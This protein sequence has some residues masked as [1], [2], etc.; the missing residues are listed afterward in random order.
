LQVYEK[1]V[2]TRVR[3][4]T[5]AAKA[6]KAGDKEAAKRHKTVADSLKITI[7]G[8]FG[9]LGNKWSTLYAPQ[10]LLQVTISGQLVLLMLIEMLEQA[11]ISVISGNTDGII[12]SYRQHRHD[13]VRAIIAMWEQRT[14]FRTEET[15]YSAIYSRDVNS[16]IAVKI[17]Q[18]DT[19]ARFLDERLGCKTKGA[20]CERGSALNSILSKNPETLVCIDAV[21]ELIKNNVPVEQT[22]RNCKDIKRFLAVRNVKGGGEKNGIYL[23]KVVRWYY[24]K[25]EAGYIAYVASGNKVAKT[26]GAK[27]LMDLPKELPGDID[28]SWYINTANEMLYDCGF[29]KTNESGSL[30]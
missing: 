9:K 16:Y 24:P 25:N 17:E 6:K 5:E 12:L 3:A 7:N 4:K 10:L 8:S 19:E 22:I 29:Y 20:Y 21:L 11:G 13:D 1:I 14:N 23:G 18:G 26:D 27:P 15:R 2:D 30:F 28:Y